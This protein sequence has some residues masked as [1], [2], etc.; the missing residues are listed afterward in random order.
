ME[1]DEKSR[2]VEIIYRFFS[3]TQKRTL[4]ELSD[5]KL[6]LLSSCKSLSPEERALVRR[7]F[8]KLWSSGKKVYATELPKVLREGK[9]NVRKSKPVKERK[10]DFL[11]SVDGTKL[12][13]KESVQSKK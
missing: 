5:D 9:Q 2:F 12:Y 1:K 3:G 4:T 6:G 11:L 7:S 10:K 13:T 8:G